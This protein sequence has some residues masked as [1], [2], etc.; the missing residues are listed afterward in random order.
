MDDVDPVRAANGAF[1]RAHE[2]RDLD[3]MAEVWHRSE[4]AVCV[5]PGWPVLRGWDQIAES[6]RRIF[7][8]PGRNQ[9]LL[10]GESFDVGADR[11]WVT[12]EE[13]L[14]DGDRMVAVSALNVFALVP[15]RWAMVAHHASPIVPMLDR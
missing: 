9:F 12:V 6:W 15:D 5:H 14:V 2:E 13:N 1:Y 4:R 8:G 7:A 10:T 11:A 3:A